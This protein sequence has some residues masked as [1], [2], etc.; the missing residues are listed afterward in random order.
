MR[1]GCL[2]RDGDPSESSAC[3]C[4]PCRR[5]CTSPNFGSAG[6]VLGAVL[7]RALTG[8]MATKPGVSKANDG[9]GR[10]GCAAGNFVPASFDYRD[11]GQVLLGRHRAAS[12]RDGW[13]GWTG[14]LG[15]EV[16]K[17]GC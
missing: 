8:E 16:Q 4:S 5:D 17:H 14:I 10:L 3:V 1:A 13:Q 6:F 7:D 15:P 9:Y 12:L 11:C 2:S